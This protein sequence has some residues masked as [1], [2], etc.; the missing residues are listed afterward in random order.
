MFRQVLMVPFFVSYLLS[1][2]A[3]A[4]EPK[5]SPSESAACSNPGMRRPYLIA[6]GGGSGSGK[7][8]I[9][10]KIEEH[11]KGE[12]LS[13]SLDN[14]YRYDPALSS[15]ERAKA[16]F[17]HPDSIDRELLVEHLQILLSGRSIQR[18]TYDFKTHSRLADQSVLIEPKATI[19]LD[20]IFALSFEEVCNLADLKIF[21]KVPRDIRLARR[22]LRD[23]H[24]RGRTPQNVIDQ[25]LETVRPMDIQY[26][27]PT[28]SVADFSISWENA[29]ECKVQKIVSKIRAYHQTSPSSQNDLTKTR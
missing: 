5:L 28:A 19:I 24:E 4:Q 13:L 20:G 14:Y 21:M 17:D 2:F 22:L 7:S 16:N 1:G 25:Y 8:T 9:V 11:C 26:I 23:I 10:K 27:Q 12:V 15:E 29:S 18:P 3:N 6:I